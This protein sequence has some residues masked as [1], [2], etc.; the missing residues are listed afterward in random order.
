MAGIGFELNKMLNRNSYWGNVSAYLYATVI[1]SGPWLISIVCL[2]ILGVYRGA[3]LNSVT[4]ELFRTTVIYSYAFSLVF[5]GTGQLVITRY[6]ADQ[7]Y[8]NKLDAIL[9]SFTT[10]VTVLMPAG[11]ALMSGFYAMTDTILLHKVL[12]VI[13]FSVICMIWLCMVYLSAIKDYH[14]IV[15][16]FSAGSAISVIAAIGLGYYFQTIGYLSGYMVGQLVIMFMLMVK[17]LIEFEPNRIWDPEL[18]RYFKKYHNLVWIGLFINLGIWIDKFIFWL[19]PD[20]RSIRLGFLTHDLYESSVFYAYITVIPT[21]ALFLI[22]IETRFYKHY[23]LYFQHIMQKKSFK[24]ITEE[25]RKMAAILRQSIR[26]IFIV[27]GII[28]SVCIIYAP[29][30]AT[31]A[32]LGALQIP[33]FRVGLAGAFLHVL[34]SI[35]V[36][37]LFYFDLRKDVLIAS[38][39]FLGLNILFTITSIH[40][41]I[42]FYAYG[43]T[44][45]ALI[46]LIVAFSMLQYR[47]EDL[48]YITFS[49]QPI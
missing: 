26:D 16:A 29:Q 6:L 11:A 42:Q 41:G 43:Y 22:K 48:E 33:S 30:L 9:A 39:L 38:A 21:L 17:I 24:T 44:Y 15:I 37:I 32:K 1:S 5:I 25:K 12:G 28:T 31:F 34:F 10:S 3:G 13:L 7:F 35:T 27:Q 20:A 19:A 40:L 49:N 47:L 2:A 36:I 18:I 8:A 45:A 46:A 4:H 14:F 23:Q